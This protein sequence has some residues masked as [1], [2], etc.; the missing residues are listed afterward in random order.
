MSK[1]NSEIFTFKDHLKKLVLLQER[2]LE[3]TSKV[4]FFVN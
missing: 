2:A 1:N 3:D 4:M